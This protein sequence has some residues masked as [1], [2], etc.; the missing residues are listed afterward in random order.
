MD[1]PKCSNSSR[2]MKMNSNNMKR[3]EPGESVSDES[4]PKL[5][6]S[7]LSST[8]AIRPGN[9]PNGQIVAAHYNE[10]KEK[11]L[12]KRKA[13]KI[14]HMRNLNNWIK[15][16]LIN[17]YCSIIK[18]R[19]KF[20]EPFWA[21]DLCCGKGGDLYKW[22]NNITH[23]IATDI[24]EVSIEDCKERYDS[25]RR[26]TAAHSLYS[27]EFFACDA[28]KEVILS[29]FR[30]PSS[31]VQITSCQFAFHYCFESFE[32]A[33]VMIR[34][35]SS[36]LEEGGFFICTIPDANEIMRRLYNSDNLRTFGNEFYNITF[37]CDINPPPLFGAKY[38]FKLED[39]VDCPEFLVHFPTM[40]QLCRR[41]GLVL[42]R[43]N[44]FVE[45]FEEKKESGL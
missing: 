29:Y 44:T 27:A 4:K 32:Q 14:I 40:V 13:S 33:N 42:V 1:E 34:N 37:Q 41:H 16:E 25:I 45:Y 43:N 38:V 22:R 10:I 31:K 30:D 6:F 8:S 3:I 23:L 35:A 7:K 5:K 12:S 36:C 39:R 11:N 2:S 19:K 17:E 28:T 26:E 15:S 18:R 20:G 9:S 24:A 21:L